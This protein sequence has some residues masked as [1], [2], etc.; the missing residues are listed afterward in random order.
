MCLQADFCCSDRLVT[1]SSAPQLVKDIQS[2]AAFVA[3][4]HD[5][6]EM[7]ANVVD[8]LRGVLHPDD[9]L[10]LAADGITSATFPWLRASSASPLPKCPVAL[11]L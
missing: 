3:D 5:G 2:A 9:S 1:D 4:D 11:P 7:T 6:P 8:W 10:R